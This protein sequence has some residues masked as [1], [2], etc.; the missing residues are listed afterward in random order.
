MISGTPKTGGNFTFTAAVTDSEQ[1]PATAPAP[2]AIS[3]RV[4][5]LVVTTGD[6]ADGGQRRRL[7]GQAGCGRRD[8]PVQVGPD[9]RLSLPAGIKLKSTG[10]LSGTSTATGPNTFTVQVTDA[11]NPAVSATETMTLYVVTPITLAASLPAGIADQFYDASPQASG[12]LGP[13]KFQYTGDVPPGV[14]VQPDGG[15]A[16]EPEEVGTF[17]FPVQVTDSEN[18]PAVVTQ[19]VS[20][21][22]TALPLTIGA[23]TLPDE[24]V[25][26]FVDE[27]LNISG[28][29]QGFS[30]GVD[31]WQ[32]SVTSGQLPPGLE[33]G[34]DGFIDG[35]VTTTG[36]YTFTVQVSDFETS[37]QTVSQTY[38]I[39]VFTPLSLTTSG[40]PGMTAGQ[41]YSATL[42]A[43]GGVAP[44]HWEVDGLPSG[45]SVDPATG[46]I[47]G[48]PVASNT[49]ENLAIDVFVTDSANNQGFGPNEQFEFFS[50]PE[51]GTLT[52]ATGP[53]PVGVD[54]PNNPTNYNSGPL[55]SGGV[56]S[57][58]ASVT[59]GSLP[60]GLRL[61]NFGPQI[62]G[63]PTAPGTYSFTVLITDSTGASV[64]FSGSIS[65]A[66]A[67]TLV[68]VTFQIF[69]VTVGQPFNYTF[70]PVGGFAPYTFTL[71]GGLP[72][73]LSLSSDG[74]IS[75]TVTGGAGTKTRSM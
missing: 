27:S 44:Y 25:N 4:A 65:I 43:T 9:G 40:L 58:T 69:S 50:V 74:V 29:V 73:G 21:T 12:G 71:Q 26:Q 14:V 75:G 6:A 59:S 10:V 8:C 11:E 62:F 46:V 15:L 53:L 51:V 36:A 30:E 35:Q 24:P 37:P 63:D 67:L 28:G 39:N 5:G 49:S 64:Q 31:G 17:T 42:S 38:T 41:P 55:A 2:E 48:T 3:V 70:Q 47:S 52:A 33:I 54:N 22:V 56:G 68:G 34:S 32:V 57:Y 66:S 13:F 72:P 16:G 23:A 19:N 61:S 7:F 45:V 60:P 18:P 20:L 1:T